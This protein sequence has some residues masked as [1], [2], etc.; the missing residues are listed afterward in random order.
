MRPI[1]QRLVLV[2]LALT[3]APAAS[4]QTV[5]EIIEKSVAAMGGRAAFGKLKSRSMTGTITF[6]S[7]AGDIQGTIEI[8]NAAPNRTRTL[9]KA[10]LS[11]IG[12]GPLVLDQRFDGSSGYILDSLQ[13]DR[14]MAG[15]QLAGA[16]NSAF[17]H[18]FVAYKN[19]G[20]VARLGGKEK[21]GAREAF[22][23]TFEPTSGPDIRA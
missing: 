9:I 18:P 5:D 8:L 11:A 6:A 2:L 4:A 13:G 19:I 21:V 3:L 23:I 1:S 20:M 17:P 15:S 7:P 16:R 10:D 14:E 22:V 12:G